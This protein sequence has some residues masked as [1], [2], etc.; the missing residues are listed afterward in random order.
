MFQVNT[1]YKIP[2]G[3]KGWQHSVDMCLTMMLVWE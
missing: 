3:E 1:M 2:K